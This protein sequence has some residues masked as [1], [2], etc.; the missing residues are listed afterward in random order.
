MA[1]FKP[2]RGKKS[3]PAQRANAIGCVL[4]LVLGFLLLF[5]MMYYTIKQG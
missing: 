4:L 3:A 1:R 5:V 2:V